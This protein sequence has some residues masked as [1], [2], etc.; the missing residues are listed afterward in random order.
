MYSGKAAAAM[1]TAVRDGRISNGDTVVFWA[2]GGTP[3][4][5]AQQ[6]QTVLTGP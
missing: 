1:F 5:F 3:A 2:T 4:L 6:Y